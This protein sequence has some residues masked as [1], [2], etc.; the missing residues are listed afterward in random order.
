[1]WLKHCNFHEHP[2]SIVEF[3]YQDSH[4]PHWHI[5]YSCIY[6]ASVN[7][8]SNIPVHWYSILNVDFGH[9]VMS[10]HR[11]VTHIHVQ[12]VDCTVP[13]S[14]AGAACTIQYIIWFPVLVAGLY[15]WLWQWLR[16][17]E[18]VPGYLLCKHTCTNDLRTH[19]HCSCT[20]L[21]VACATCLR[22]EHVR[23]STTSVSTLS[24]NPPLPTPFY[25]RVPEHNH[26]SVSK[27][28]LVWLIKVLNFL[29]CTHPL[30]WPYLH[31]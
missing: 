3:Q 7:P 20:N 21:R 14:S 10:L 13:L 15:W 9:T 26:Y 11:I 29:F 30:P 16:M 17:W 23:T 6:D 5:T 27:D 1:M 8:N 24:E 31:S 28:W 4:V 19:V 22:V 2:R 12:N 25:T 18:S